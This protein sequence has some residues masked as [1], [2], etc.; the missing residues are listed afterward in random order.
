MSERRDVGTETLSTKYASKGDLAD[1]EVRGLLSAVTCDSMNW[2]KCCACVILARK[3]WC[4]K[5]DCQACVRD[6]S[7]L[8]HFGSLGCPIN[9]FVSK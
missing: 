3:T 4:A 5:D 1:D 7:L 6:V 9:A 2:T 8:K